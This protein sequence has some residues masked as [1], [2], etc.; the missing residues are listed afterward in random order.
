MIKIYL[1]LK[2]SLVLLEKAGHEHDF[3]MSATLTK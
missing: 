2:K 3:K 1:E